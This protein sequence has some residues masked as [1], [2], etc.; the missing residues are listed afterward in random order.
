M[1]LRTG[2]NLKLAHCVLEFSVYYLRA[3]VGHRVLKLDKRDHCV[4][5]PGCIQA[6]GQCLRLPS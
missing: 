5:R 4:N 3:V 6:V 1:L 2:C